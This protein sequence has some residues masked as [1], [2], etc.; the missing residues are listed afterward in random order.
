[1]FYLLLV[2]S[3]RRSH[4]RHSATTCDGRPCSGT[5]LT[6]NRQ[7]SSV[8]GMPKNQKRDRA[9]G[10]VSIPQQASVTAFSPAGLSGLSAF[11]SRSPHVQMWVM[12]KKGDICSWRQKNRVEGPGFFTFIRR[13]NRSTVHR[14]RGRRSHPQGGCRVRV[15]RSR[16]IVRRPISSAGSHGP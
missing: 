9:N 13:W 4:P 2:S 16:S 1:M 14:D 8:R 15:R 10:D 7:W 6:G 11:F 12:Q 3:R 5:R